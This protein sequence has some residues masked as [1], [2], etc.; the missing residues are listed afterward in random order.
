VFHLL[1]TLSLV[2]EEHL[3]IHGL[4]DPLDGVAPLYLFVHGYHDLAVVTVDFTRD[5]REGNLDYVHAGDLHY[6]LSAIAFLG[7]GEQLKDLTI[8]TLGIH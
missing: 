3:V 6:A 8:L 2:V 1:T 7:L 5:K 4:G